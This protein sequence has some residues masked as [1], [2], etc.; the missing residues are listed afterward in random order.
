MIVLWILSL[1]LAIP[2]AWTWGHCSARIVYRPIGS[3]QHRD[4]LQLDAHERAQFRDIE[5]HFD[6]IEWRPEA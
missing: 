5:Q 1:T 4:E 3:D 6:G 2:A